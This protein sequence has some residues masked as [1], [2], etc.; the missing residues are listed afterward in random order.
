[1]TKIPAILAAMLLAAAIPASAQSAQASDIKVQRIW[2]HKYSAFTSIAEFH[3]KYYVAFR[4]AGG[5]IW[6][7]KGKA[8]GEIRIISSKDGNEWKSV[9]LLSKKE[10]DLR[11][12]KL[13][14][15]PDG[16]L[17]V[18]MGGSVYKGKALVRSF[19]R[20]KYLASAVQTIMAV[21]V[22]KNPDMY[23]LLVV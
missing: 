6:D 8:E 4:E 1:M 11:D 23:E 12:P 17:L 14:V 13:T 9:A 15:T 16:K 3:G 10:F 2:N 21:L 19:S 20:S 7:S 5:H 22:L 18:T